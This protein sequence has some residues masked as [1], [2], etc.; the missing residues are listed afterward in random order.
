MTVHIAGYASI[1]FGNINFLVQR[2]WQENGVASAP[3]TRC[4]A[5]RSNE[6]RAAFKITQT[7]RPVTQ[8]LIHIGIGIQLFGSLRRDAAIHPVEIQ[9]FP[10]LQFEL[11]TNTARHR[12]AEWEIRF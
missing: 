12:S 4:F 11:E 1:F 7:R 3:P 6:K 9:V 2:K 10:I 8:D 5:F